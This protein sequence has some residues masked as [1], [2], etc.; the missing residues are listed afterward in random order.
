MGGFFQEQN[1]KQN[2]WGGANNWEVASKPTAA[3]APLAERIGLWVVFCWNFIC[4]GRRWC[5]IF[6]S[7]NKVCNY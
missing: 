5:R 1:Q 6:F 2:S 3:T 7:F 4:N